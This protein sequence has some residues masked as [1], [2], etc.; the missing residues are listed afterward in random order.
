MSESR[1]FGIMSRGATHSAGTYIAVFKLC[2]TAN[3]QVPGLYLR[4]YGLR[5]F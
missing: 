4:T 3:T 5:G 1:T 2:T